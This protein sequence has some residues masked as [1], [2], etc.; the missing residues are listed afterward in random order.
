MIARLVALSVTHRFAILLATILLVVVGVRGYV[1]LTVDA[2]PDV[3]N[4]QVQV[5]TNAPGLSPLEVEQLVTRPVELAMTGHPWR[6]ETRSISRTRVSAVT[7]VFNDDVSLESARSLVSQRLPAAR[8]AIPAG[9][10]SAPSSGRSRPA[11][12]RSTTSPWSGRGT[13]RATSARSSTGRS[14][15]RCARCPAWSR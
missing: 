8:E 13:T 6:R 1:T 14:P 9:A 12:A 4:V 5:L 15:T 11:S 10:P 2:V 3:T 7:V